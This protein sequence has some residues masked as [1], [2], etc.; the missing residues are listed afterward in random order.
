MRNF[1]NIAIMNSW[2]AKEE[3]KGYGYVNNGFEFIADDKN[4]SRHEEDWS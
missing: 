1:N 2:K 3:A 4:K